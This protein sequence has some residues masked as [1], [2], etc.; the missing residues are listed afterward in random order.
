MNPRI[1]KTGPAKN[2][3]KKLPTPPL[4]LLADVVEKDLGLPPPRD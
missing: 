4:E 1:N 2:P 3:K